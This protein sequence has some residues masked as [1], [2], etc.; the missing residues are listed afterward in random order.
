MNI[1]VCVDDN[2]GM[3]FHNRRQSQDRQLREYVLHMVSASSCKLWVNSYTIKQFSGDYG[4]RIIVDDFF[5]EKSSECDYCF[6]ENTDII[7]YTDK[8]NRI[9]LFKWNRIYPADKFFTLDISNWKLEES[10]EFAGSSHE[11]IT[12]E[13]YHR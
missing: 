13:I 9:I 10:L 8:I 1:I 6:V 3:M 2:N 4:N 5:L 11:K 12:K 7:P